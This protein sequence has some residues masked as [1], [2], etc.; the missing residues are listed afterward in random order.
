M[1]RHLMAE[2]SMEIWD[3][4]NR[5]REVI[6][7]HVRGTELP[8]NGF[9]LVVHVW[10][11]NGRDKYLMTQRSK[12]K[13]TFPLMWECVGGSVLKGE[14]SIQ[15]ALRELKEEV[16]LELDAI[17]GELLFTKWRGA[18]EGKRYNDIVDVWLFE[19]DGDVLLE[20]ATTDEVAQVRWMSREEIYGLFQ[21]NK[22]VHSIKDLTYFFNEMFEM[23]ER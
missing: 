23:P 7:E 4:Y 17:A 6:G 19:Y 3:L 9:H 2:K 10:I 18:V 13:A 16:G 21:D 12:D 8:K 5:E 22:I 14:E 1:R 20:N 15:G 11:K